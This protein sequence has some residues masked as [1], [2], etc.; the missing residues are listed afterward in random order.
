M[1]DRSQIRMT[2][3]GARQ[4]KNN[5][6]TIPR[7]SVTPTTSGPFP[8]RVRQDGAEPI[9]VERASAP[10]P[11]RMVPIPADATA[12]AI[13]QG[14]AS[15]EARLGEI[16]TVLRQGYGLELDDLRAQNEQLRVELN[17]ALQEI[18]ALRGVSEPAAE[19][20]A[21]SDEPA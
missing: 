20:A 9:P 1:A 4:D 19:D 10:Q 16:V 18:D 13:S 5:V 2:R 17:V 3:R 8:R 15:M 21:P 11:R 6:R 7:I 14:M 12:A